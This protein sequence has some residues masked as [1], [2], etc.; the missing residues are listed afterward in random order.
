MRSITASF[1]GG[2]KSKWL[3]VKRDANTS[4][5]HVPSFYDGIQGFEFRYYPWLAKKNRAEV[6][7]EIAT[8]NWPS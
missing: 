4:N 6:T 2:L 3:A 5:S 8:A 7:N 1:N